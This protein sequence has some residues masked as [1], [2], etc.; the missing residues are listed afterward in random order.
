MKSC[1]IYSKRCLWVDS[2]REDI[3]D[4][5]R[6]NILR[7]LILIKAM[8][9]QKFMLTETAYSF[10]QN[11]PTARLTICHKTVHCPVQQNSIMRNFA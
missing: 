5:Y 1:Q 9:E 6:I 2:F 8:L 10:F 3:I 11:K 7:L 4:H